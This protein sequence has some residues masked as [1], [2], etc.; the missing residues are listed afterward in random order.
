VCTATEFWKSYILIYVLKHVLTLE[1]LLKPGSVNI[2]FS[3][4][5]SIPQGLLHLPDIFEPGTALTVHI[6]VK[7]V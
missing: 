2:W 1:T 6:S 4:D 3:T 7:N 5:F